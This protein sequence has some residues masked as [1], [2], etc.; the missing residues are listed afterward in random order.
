MCFCKR[1]RVAYT[2]HPRIVYQHRGSLALTYI[3]RPIRYCLHTGLVQIR[4]SHMFCAT[5]FKR[6]DRWMPAK[7]AIHFN[8]KILAYS[9]VDRA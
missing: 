4:P 3:D 9:M 7:N 6:H 2:F 5:Y 8:I 1:Y